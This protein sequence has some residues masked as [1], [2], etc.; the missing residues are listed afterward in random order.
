MYNKIKTQITCKTQ[1][2]ASFDEHYWTKLLEMWPEWIGETETGPLC[3]SPS[4]VSC[5]AHIL[6]R[7][8]L[9]LE[10]RITTLHLVQISYLLHLQD[11]KFSSVESA[12]PWVGGLN[13]KVEFYNSAHK[14][15]DN[16]AIVLPVF[17]KV[18]REILCLVCAC[19]AKHTPIN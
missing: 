6:E 13:I 19:S 8:L 7:N 3:L 18:V 12:Y 10:G 9:Y 14:H 5:G 15:D 2:K 16:S 4:C 17:L 11:C 1:N